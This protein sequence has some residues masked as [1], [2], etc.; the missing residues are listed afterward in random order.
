MARRAYIDKGRAEMMTLDTKNHT[1]YNRCG[2]VSITKLHMNILAAID[3]SPDFRVT[4]HELIRLA[5]PDE[6][7][8]SPQRVR[9]NISRLNDVISEIGLRIDFNRTDRTYALGI[10]SE[11]A[12]TDD[13]TMIAS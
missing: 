2:R 10:I 12:G 8:I 5:W 6:R 11:D 1:A 4:L 13:P 9:V 7:A 3:T